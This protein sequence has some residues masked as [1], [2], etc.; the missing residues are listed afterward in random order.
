MRMLLRALSAETLKLKR[1]LAVWVVA[2]APMV[3]ILLTVLVL[4]NP[5][6]GSTQVDVLKG[7]N[8]GSIGV[9]AV[10][11]LPLFIV[12][13]TAL[14]SAIDHNSKSWKHL[15]AMPIPR[16]AIYTAKL[17]AGLALTA[18]STLVLW[19]GLVVTGL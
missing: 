10:F 13:E 6:R 19:L 3:V 18:A 5:P 7:M 11:M 17:F 2:G 4:L 1:T 16:W 12:L 14:V 15:Y 9:W 8:Q